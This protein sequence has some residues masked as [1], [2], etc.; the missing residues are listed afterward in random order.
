MTSSVAGLPAGIRA[1]KRTP[2]FTQETVPAGLLRDH[3]TKAGTWALIHVLEGALLYVVPSEGF[4]QVLAPGKPPGVVRPQQL[5]SVKP[6]GPVRFYVE[7]HAAPPD[8]AEG[9]PSSGLAG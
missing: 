9:S 6:L 8:E 4:Q 7:F 1:Y 3:T 5:H 2:E